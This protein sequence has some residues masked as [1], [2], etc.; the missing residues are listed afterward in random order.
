MNEVS[1]AMK[2][3]NHFVHG[4]EGAKEEEPEHE[5]KENTLEKKTILHSQF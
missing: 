4:L 2:E 1:V 5:V 3:K